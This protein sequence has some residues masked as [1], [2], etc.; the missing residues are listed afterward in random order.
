MTTAD[1][2]LETLAKHRPWYR[3]CAFCTPIASDAKNVSDHEES[4]PW[5]R[6][7]G[8]LA[9]R[10]F[11]DN[12]RRTIAEVKKERP[13]RRLLEELLYEVRKLDKCLM[14]EHRTGGPYRIEHDLVR[15]VLR[16]IDALKNG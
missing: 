1:E 6:E 13:K 3:E 16:R 11:I 2:F 8:V 4:C 15:D 7:L 5:K 12:T 9:L 10:V 14:D